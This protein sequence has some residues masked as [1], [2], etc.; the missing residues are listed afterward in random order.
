MVLGALFAALV[1]AAVVLA[2]TGSFTRSGWSKSHRMS[3]LYTLGSA[4]DLYRAQQGSAPC[5]TV[6]DLFSAGI[7]DHSQDTQDPWDQPYRI[8]CDGD[9]VD[10]RIR[11]SGPDRVFGT[12]D[13]LSNLDRR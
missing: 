10:T 12:D 13:D 2:H 1:C 8:E 11:S 3:A 4:A 9:E 6:Q 5:P 7:L